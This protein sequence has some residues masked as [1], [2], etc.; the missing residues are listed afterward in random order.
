M[1]QRFLKIVSTSDVKEGKYGPY[2][3]VKFEPKYMLSDG[4]PVASALSEGTRTVFGQ[5][6]IEGKEIKADGLFKS[7]TAGT[8]KEGSLV[9]GHIARVS[10][11]PYQI[12]GRERPVTQW[13]GVIFG[14]ENV[15][16]YVNKQFFNSKTPACAVNGDMLT[17]PDNLNIPLPVNAS[18][19]E[20]VPAG[21][22]V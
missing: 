11:T 8:C 1:I 4:T 2:I 18:T 16:D 14:H 10:T 15:F 7:I 9:E 13:T 21:E 5:S 12:P 6:I 20:T 19:F 3:I 17:A 22:T